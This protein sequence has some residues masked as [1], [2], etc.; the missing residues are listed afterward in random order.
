MA[1]DADAVT[2]YTDGGADPNPGPGGW[3][4][5]LIEASGR[6]RELSGGAEKTTNNRM[7]LSA[8]IEALASLEGRRRVELYTDSQYLRQGITRWLRGWVAKGWKRKDGGAVANVDL[9]RRLAALTAEH[10][11]SWHWVKGHS[12]DRHNER[13][14]ELAGAEIRRRQ[15]AARGAR[16]PATAAASEVP[17]AEV[18]LKV[19]CVGARGAWAAL[20]REGED[21]RTAH[22]AHRGVTANRLDILAACEVLESLPEGASV[23]MHT[24]S[25]YLRNGASQWL[26]GWRRRGFKTAAGGAVK[27][28]DDWRRLDAAM[29]KRRVSWPVDK[30]KKS[31]ELKALEPVVK[32]AMA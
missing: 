1:S 10:E 13:A 6:T 25:D 14:D 16:A 3:G 28:A 31:D 20:I 5:V 24:G 15:A 27:N 22:A 7:E 11:V 23:A 32:A 19:R 26:S 30:S 17:D 8:A 9:W 29:K 2:I 21:E 18:F 12:G 4:A